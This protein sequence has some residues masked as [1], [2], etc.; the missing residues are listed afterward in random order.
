VAAGLPAKLLSDLRLAGFLHDAGKADGRFQAWLHYSDPFGPGTDDGAVV[1]AKSGRALPRAARIGSGLPE[2]WRHE[3]L[4]VRLA[5][6]VTRFKHEARDPELVLWLIGSHHG[7]G[8][9]FF[10]HADPDDGKPQRLPAVI[11]LPH[12]LPPG[13]GPQSLAFDWQGLDWP[14]LFA[15]LKAR[16]GVWE[17]ARMEAIVRLADHRASQDASNTAAA[18]RK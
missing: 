14:A 4:S 16:Y 10:P 15:R 6:H 17:L 12:E 8:R 2:N 18:E 11:D 3:A 1:L 7:Y 5:P 13:P 9:P